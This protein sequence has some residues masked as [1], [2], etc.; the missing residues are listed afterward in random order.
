MALE[1][2]RDLMTGK[3]RRLIR[4]RAI[5]QAKR[6]IALENR[7]VEDFS[8]DELEVVVAEEERKLLARLSHVSLGGVLV[9]LGLG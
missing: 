4:E 7:R 1:K 2:V 6:R 9:L 5:R 8:R 3:A